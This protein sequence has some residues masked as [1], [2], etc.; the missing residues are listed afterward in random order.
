V[1]DLLTGRIAATINSALGS[2]FLDADLVR[3]VPAAVQTDKLD[4]TP[5]T[6]RYSCKA[7][8]ERYG[9]SLIRDGLVQTDDVRVLIL[10]N[11]L[12]VWGTTEDVSDAIQPRPGDRITIRHRTFV[13]VPAGTGGQPAVDG[14]AARAVWDCRCR[15]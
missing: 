10:A 4:P 2:I 15:G 9:A 7:I 12:K 3:T 5:A 13:I 8:H 1:S 14:D 6:Y 11:S